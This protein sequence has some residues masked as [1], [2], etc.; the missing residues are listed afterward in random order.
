MALPEQLVNK[1]FS[2]SS[3]TNTSPSLVQVQIKGFLAHIAD[4]D[5]ALFILLTYYIAHLKIHIAHFQMD[6]FADAHACG[7]KKLQHCLVTNAFWRSQVWLL[8]EIVYLLD[9]EN[10]RKLLLHLGRFQIVCRVL[11]DS[12]Q[13]EPYAGKTHAWKQRFWK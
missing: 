4:G 8:Q 9:A 11:I 7:I 13:G 2:L 10:L 5:N 12:S 3:F 6:Q 1:A